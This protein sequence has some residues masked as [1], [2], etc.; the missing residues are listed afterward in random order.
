[1]D[2]VEAVYHESAGRPA[3]ERF[4]LTSQI[5]RAAISIPSNIAEGYGRIHRK[6]YVHHLAIARGSTME[7]ET[8]L[9]LAVRLGYAQR[10]EATDVWT[11]LQETGRLLHA[12][13]RS[14]RPDP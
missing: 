4:G 7:V 1:M 9:I 6:E 8:Q 3:D 10:D 12:L 13:I 2:L 5:R 11:L 14:L